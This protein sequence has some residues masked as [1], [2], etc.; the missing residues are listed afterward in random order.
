MAGAG[1]ALL[2]CDA[3]HRPWRLPIDTMYMYTRPPPASCGGV[4]FLSSILEFSTFLPAGALSVL[5]RWAQAMSV[6]EGQTTLFSFRR[7]G[8]LA[9]HHRPTSY[10]ASFHLA[11]A[12]KVTA[13]ALPTL[14][15]AT[16]LLYAISPIPIQSPPQTSPT[17]AISSSSSP[18]APNLAAV[19][20]RLGLTEYLHVLTDNG[21]HNWETVVD[22]TEDD[23]T[24]LN[25]KLGHRRLLQREI[26]TYRGIPQSLSLEPEANS[27]EST[28][29]STSAL[30]S[31]TRQTTTPPPREKRRYRRHPRPDAHAPKKPKTACMHHPRARPDTRPLLTCCQTSTLLTSFAPTPKSA[32]CPLSTLRAKLAADG[33]SSHQRRSAS[34]RAMPHVPCKSL[35]PRWTSTRKRTTTASIK[36]I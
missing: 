36:P 11:P 34:G 20:H 4:L 6:S 18:T 7:S 26:A 30:E 35:R 10:N 17:M 28:S 15:G 27:P 14:L 22:I 25:F 31:F 9:H 23:L 3:H 8:S 24:T 5:H 12:G 2:Q 16:T 13:A 32:S 19:L 21:F 29:L 1:R 33:R